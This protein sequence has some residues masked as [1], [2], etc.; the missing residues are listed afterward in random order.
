MKLWEAV[1]ALQEGKTVKQTMTRKI[2]FHEKGY[3]VSI[4]IDKDDIS[5]CEVT[6][7]SLMERLPT[8]WEVVE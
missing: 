3:L 6:L 7:T 2:R 8:G 1:K 4:G 5:P